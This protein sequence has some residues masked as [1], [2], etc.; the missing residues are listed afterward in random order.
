MA[1]VAGQVREL[2]DVPACDPN[3]SEARV[4]SD[5]RAVVIVYESK[6]EGWPD[7]ESCSAVRFDGC[8][9]FACGGPTDEAFGNHPL[10]SL[11]L[12]PYALQE[13]VASP[14]I[15]TRAA[16]EART[17]RLRS[18]LETSQRH[19]VFALKEGTFECLAKSYSLIG[20]FPTLAE[21][22]EAARA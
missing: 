8:S 12:Q 19:F 20:T 1:R 21:A 14:F 3:V 4:T 11:G 13:V 2:V 15:A 16:I 22:I 18:I 17:A 9:W 7:V 10:Y 6:T 5:G